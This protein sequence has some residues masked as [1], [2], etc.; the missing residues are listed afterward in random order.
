LE[1]KCCLHYVKAGRT[2]I[3]QGDQDSSLFFVVT[4][5]LQVLQQ[6]VGKETE[7][8]RLNNLQKLRI[9]LISCMRTKIVSKIISW[10]RIKISGRALE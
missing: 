6:V 3:S 4:G 10:T 7:E 5:Q 2:L 8:V 9:E 1:G